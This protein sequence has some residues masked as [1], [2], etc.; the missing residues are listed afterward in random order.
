MIDVYFYEAFAEEE[1]ALRRYLP[2]EIS[3]EY[4][5]RTIQE[6]DHKLP[7]ARMISTRTQSRFQAGWNAPLAAILSR[8]YVY[9]QLPAYAAG[10][11]KHPASGS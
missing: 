11:S 5:D 4:T 3:A 9:A 2:K 1:E 10:K 8:S 6:C 7:P